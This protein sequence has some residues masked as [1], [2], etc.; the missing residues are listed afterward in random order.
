MV[1]READGA[2]DNGRKRL[3]VAESQAIDTL[4]IHGGDQHDPGHGAIFPPITTATTFVQSNLGEHG[5]FCY[6]RCANPTRHAFETALAALEGGCFCTATASGMA[7]TALA[8]ELLAHGSHVVVMRGVYGGTHRLFER[9][10]RH[11]MDLDFT[12]VDLNDASSVGD[13]IRANTRMVWVESPTNPLLELVDIP[14]LA[15][16]VRAAA[17][18]RFVAQAPKVDPGSSADLLEG[19]ILICADNTFAT[20]WNQ[21]PIA[22]GADLVMLSSSKYIGGHSDMTG[23][24]LIT[25]DNA[26][27]ERLGFLKSS[28][29]AIASPFEAYLALRGLKTLAVRMERQCANA[30]KVAEYLEGHPRIARVYYPGL[31]S[32][33][34]FELCRRQMRS[35]GAVVSVRLASVAGSEDLEMMKAFFAR[36]RYWVLAES[37]GGVES[38]INHSATMSHGSM[39]REE[40]AEVGVHDTTL[41]LSVGLEAADDL[42]R[43]LGHALGECDTGEKSVAPQSDRA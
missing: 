22:L 25:N 11:T 30:Q 15:T 4:A 27:A 1:D 32:S 3:K 31:R 39:S 28:I 36:L 34:Q 23:G 21:R 26:I 9:V 35:G 5:A 12:Y 17:T 7:A 41:R 38:M 14:T 2:G 19:R 10:R 37:L 33:P 8:L 40:R 24:A 42:I 13:C 6:S 43:D 20:A 18:A 16:A 29:G